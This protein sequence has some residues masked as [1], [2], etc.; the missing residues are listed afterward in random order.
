MVDVVAWT[1]PRAVAYAEA[2]HVR[3]SR[4]MQ[5]AVLSSVPAAA[6]LASSVLV[7]ALLLLDGLELPW[8]VLGAPAFFLLIFY[9]L[10]WLHAL[11][12]RESRYRISPTHVQIRGKNFRWRDFD[13]YQV[14]AHALVR[15]HDEVVL[16]TR[17]GR[18]RKLPLPEGEPGRHV[19][20]AI[21][22]NLPLLERKSSDELVHLLPASFGWLVYGSLLI[23]STAVGAFLLSGSFPARLWDGLATLRLTPLLVVGPGWLAAVVLWRE[24]KYPRGACAS[25][26]VLIN[27]ASMMMITMWAVIARAEGIPPV[28]AHAAGPTHEPAFCPRVVQPPNP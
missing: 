24:H 18:Q 20:Q 4:V 10:P 15:E 28:A 7:P 5:T 2:R 27:W 26:A 19:V 23:W 8:E 6:L 22:R 12:P 11:Q 16:H 3:D 25:A 21:A 13:G 14:R 17:E 1:C 9:F